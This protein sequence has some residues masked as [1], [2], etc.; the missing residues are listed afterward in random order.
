M[1]NH[2]PKSNVHLRKNTKHLTVRGGW[3]GVN[4]YGQPDRKISVLFLTTSLTLAQRIEVGWSIFPQ[5]GANISLSTSNMFAAIFSHRGAKQI[6]L[7]FP[8]K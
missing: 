1:Y 3:G 7:F 6:T 4:P 8:D 2:K 5:Q